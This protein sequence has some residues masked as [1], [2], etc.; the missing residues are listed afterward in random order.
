MFDEQT[1]AMLW[2][3]EC[4]PSLLFS[5]KATSTGDHNRKGLKRVGATIYVIIVKHPSASLACNM[6]GWMD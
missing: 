5:I 6:D 3:A 4:M 2:S 1:E